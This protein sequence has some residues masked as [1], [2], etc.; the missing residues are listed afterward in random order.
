LFCQK[1]T[2]RIDSIYIWISILYIWVSILYICV[3]ILYIWVSIL[4]IWVSILYI[5]VSILYIWVSILYIWVSILPLSTMFVFCC[6]T[7]YYCYKIILIQLSS[8]KSSFLLH[9]T[10]HQ[11]SVY[12]SR[13]CRPF[14]LEYRVVENIICFVRNFYHSS[15]KCRNAGGFENLTL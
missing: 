6:F 11:M 2:T 10:H 8:T 4:Y 13:I 9:T 3:S 1:Y 12:I 5:W 15:I 7:L 14:Y